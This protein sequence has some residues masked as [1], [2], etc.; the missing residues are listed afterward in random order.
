MA[1]GRGVLRWIALAAVLA[2]PGSAQTPRGEVKGSAWQHTAESLKGLVAEADVALPPAVTGGTV[3]QGKWKDMPAGSTVKVPVVVFMH[4]SSGLGLK[5]IGEWQQW[6][7]GLGVASVAANS[8]ALPDRLT[9]T[10]PVGKDVYEKIHA[11]RASE[12]APMLAALKDRA[13]ADPKRLVLAGASEGGVPVARYGGPEFAARIIYSWSCENN[14]YVEEPRTQVVAGQPVLNVMSSSDP[15]F[16]PSLPWL[17]NPAAR[18]SAA[19]AFKDS[20]TTT[21]VLVPGAPH[22][23]LNL[24]Q[25]RAVTRSFLED[26]VKP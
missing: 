6:L 3:F 14:Y 20:K 17:G 13:W 4:G 25:V 9:Y 18:G 12:I 19:E 23:L 5:A 11:L 7:A 21:I 26:A 2:L 22:T 16:S 10:S 1:P 15:Y 8:F 24:P